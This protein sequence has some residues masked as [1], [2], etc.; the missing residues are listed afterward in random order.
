MKLRTII[1][2]ICLCSCWN[3]EPCQAQQSIVTLSEPEEITNESTGKKQSVLVIISPI[4]TL[5][6]ESNMGD[7]CNTSL[8]DED[9]FR[10]TLNIKFS[11]DELDG[12]TTITRIVKV[13]SEYG[14]A[15]IR[16]KFQPGK[17]YKAY[18][19]VPP[20]FAYADESISGGIFAS[21]Q[22]KISFV[23]KLTD[24]DLYY[25]NQQ[26]LSAGKTSSTIPSYITVQKEEDCYNLLF[27]LDGV[28]SEQTTFKRPEIKIEHKDENNKT[29]QLSIVLKEGTE[30]GSKTSLKYRVFYKNVIGEKEIITVAKDLTFDELMEKAQTH[31]KKQDYE[32]AK[33]TYQDAMDHIGCPLDQKEKI[34]SMKQRAEQARKLT[35]VK[36]RF[37]K[38][39]DRLETE[40]GFSSDSTYTYCAA[41]VKV[42]QDMIVL[43]PNNIELQD[44]LTQSVE[45]L[46][47]HPKSQKVEQKVKV[48]HKQIISGKVDKED[49]FIDDVAGIEIYASHE[50]KPKMKDAKNMQRLGRVSSNGTYKIMFQ[51][52][53][54]YLYF[55]GAKQAFPITEVT[56]TLDVILE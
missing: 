45:K 9:K 50:R 11:T 13:K 35:F 33:N 20:E 31:E 48:N 54:S 18:F 24:L 26:I 29:N 28:Q 3:S 49:S 14:E 38:N 1:S 6:I 46:Y 32:A 52:P 16:S 43:Y 51:P 2:I 39:I 53:V 55:Y 10:H 41:V 40:Y 34:R 44:K 47:R 30:I 5:T 7:V 56:Q 17:Q 42:N 19:E 21:D 37:E 23:S 36:A 25:N 27:R 4:E 15:N 8:P 22:A 12:A